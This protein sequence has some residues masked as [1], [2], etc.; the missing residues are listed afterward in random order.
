M[1]NAKREPA[2][3]VRASQRVKTLEAISDR[4]FYTTY[5]TRL[6]SRRDNRGSW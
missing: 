3:V 5:T 6:Q 1:G 2:R 4:D